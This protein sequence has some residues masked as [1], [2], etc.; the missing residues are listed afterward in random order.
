MALWFKERGTINMKTMFSKDY[1][2]E[3]DPSQILTD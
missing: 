2:E 1:L 3:K